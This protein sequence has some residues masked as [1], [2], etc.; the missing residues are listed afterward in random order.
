MCTPARP[1]AGGAEL[2]SATQS[3]AAAQARGPGLNTGTSAV[4]RTH[5]GNVPASAT[6]TRLLTGRSC[7]APGS[8]ETKPLC[9]TQQRIR[10]ALFCLP[11]L[12]IQGKMQIVFGVSI[13]F[14][15]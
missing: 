3:S 15:F 11:T 8:L 10:E 14:F 7:R 1:D 5:Q 6:A 12:G 4:H 2:R 13:D 9:S